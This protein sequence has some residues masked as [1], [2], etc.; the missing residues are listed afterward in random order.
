MFL[1]H[2]LKA[3]VKN[4]EYWKNEL[5]DPQIKK[6]HKNQNNNFFCNKI[7]RFEFLKGLKE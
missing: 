1:L 2:S 4:R 6:I 5:K 7:W 3:K